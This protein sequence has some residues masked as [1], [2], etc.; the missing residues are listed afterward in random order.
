MREVRPVG[1]A[2]AHQIVRGTAGKD[3]GR[4]IGAARNSP[5]GRT[6]RLGWIVTRRRVVLFSK[7]IFGHGED[8][9]ILIN[10]RQDQ[11]RPDLFHP[12]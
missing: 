6:E 10:G 9:L 7:K 2:V 4:Q 3:Q 5:S 11:F 12:P 8:R 1:Q